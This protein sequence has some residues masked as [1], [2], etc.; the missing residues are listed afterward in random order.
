[1]INRWALLVRLALGNVGG[2]AFIKALKAP[3][4]QMP[5]VPARGV[6][7][8]TAAAFITARASALGT[9]LI[10]ESTLREGKHTILRKPPSSCLHRPR[11]RQCFRGLCFPRGAR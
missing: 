6:T 1:M 10:S 11:Y 8:Q 9:D 3:L 4:P 2:P 7:P 5:L